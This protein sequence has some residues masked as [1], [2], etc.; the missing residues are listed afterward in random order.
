MASSSQ[1]SNRLDYL[2]AARALALL[3]G[4]VFHAS[5]SFMPMFIGWAV[6]DISTSNI[7][8]IFVM[9]SHS[10]RMELFFLIAGFFSHMTL[11]KKG[12]RTF[13][14][15]RI[16]RIGLPLLIGWFILRPML[17]SGWIM[18]AESM[19]GDT[20]IANA[21]T[22]GLASL[23]DLPGGFLVGTHLWF[24]YYLLLIPALTLFVC[25]MVSLNDKVKHTLSASMDC[26]VTWLCRSSFAPFLVVLPIGSCLW[27]M[28]HWGMD[29][30]DKSLIP[31]LPVLFVYTGF[32]SFGWLM[33][34]QKQQIQYFAKITWSKI[35][36][37]LSATVL[38]VIL[39]SFQS[40]LGHPHYH[41]LKIVF[42]LNYALMMWTLVSLFIGLCFRSFN[43]LN[44]VIRYLADASYWLYLIHLPIVIWLQI[45]F[46]EIDSHW[47][48]KLFG[49]CTITVVLSLTLYELF[50]RSTIIGRV[51]NGR[52]K[53]RVLQLTAN[54]KVKA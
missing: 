51:L 53:P 39:T 36:I 44:H 4:I 16:M 50:V 6:M 45:A 14:S 20:D 35:I 30:P 8:A 2:D 9:I 41:L 21:L 33:N 10:F 26:L 54:S 32:F 38:T 7:V 11:Q 27:F 24:L 13:I 43:R 46:A 49:I 47:S 22:Q 18:G 31:N 5:L 1:T 29:T 23:K 28:S 3:L 15:T 12:I 25:S 42:V 34:R 40:Q 19:R 37:C 52:K 48:F 17:V